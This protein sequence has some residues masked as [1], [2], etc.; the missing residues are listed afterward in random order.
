VVARRVVAAQIIDT[1]LTV[2]TDRGTG[3]QRLL[4]MHA[5]AVDGVAG[6]EIVGAVEH[7][8]D[9]RDQ[10]VERF[11]R[12]PLLQ[13]DDLDLGIDGVQRLPAGLRLGHADAG[14]GMEN[15]PLQ[16]G[17]IDGVVIDQSHLA[18]PGRSQ[19]ECRRRPQAASPDHQRMAG[20]NARLAFDAERI[21]EDMA[22]VA[23]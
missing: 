13:R 6:G 20:Q 18:D 16:I 9:R 17:E 4:V 21:E 23:E 8:I 14:L 7:D 10:R 3:N 15:L 5:G 12:Q 11:A 22:A 1:D 2:E 19:V